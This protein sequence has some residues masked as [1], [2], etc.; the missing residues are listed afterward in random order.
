[1]Q[2]SA[3]PKGVDPTSPT[4]RVRRDRHGHDGPL[5]PE[6]KETSSADDSRDAIVRISARAAQLSKGLTAAEIEE[7]LQAHSDLP[8]DSRKT[9]EAIMKKLAPDLYQALVEA[10]EIE[11]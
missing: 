1:M 4:G 7:K 9:A 6:Q 10:G 8:V 5:R 11:E 3:G 2:M